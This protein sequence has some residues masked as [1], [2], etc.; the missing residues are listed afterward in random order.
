MP[1]K[2]VDSQKISHIR[3]SNMFNSSVTKIGLVSYIFYEQYQI[4]VYLFMSLYII[5]PKMIG[6]IFL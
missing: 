2:E 4:C 1:F 5:A 6:H 3:F